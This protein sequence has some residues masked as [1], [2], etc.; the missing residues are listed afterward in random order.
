[1]P[2]GT[3]KGL[4]GAI[5]QLDNDHKRYRGKGMRDAVSFINDYLSKKLVG[6]EMKNQKDID[7]FL[8]DMRDSTSTVGSNVTLSVSK[9]VLNATAASKGLTLL[10]SLR[11]G[12]NIIMPTPLLNIM[13][14]GGHANSQLDFQDFMLIP[15][16]ATS[17]STAIEYGMEISHALVDVLDRRG[18]KSEICKQ[19]C[20]A[21]ILSS[22]EQAIEYILAAIS[23]AGLKCGADIFLGLDLASNAFYKHEKYFLN[24][25]DCAICSDELI[26]YLKKLTEQYP[27]ISIEDG[28][29]EEDLTG[30]KKITS[31]L[32]A[33]IQLVGDDLFATNKNLLLQGIEDNIA[34]AILIKP[35]QVGTITETINTV[36]EAQKHN[37]QNIFSVRASETEDISLSCLCVALGV[38]QFKTGS[39]SSS[40]KLLKI[41]Q[42][43]R[44]E[45]LYGADASYAGIKPFKSISN[46]C[47]DS[48]L[49]V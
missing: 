30:W 28:V 21:P 13:S 17:Y 9:A 15:A 2:S 43:L 37:Y 35:N 48:S 19:N 36:K 40:D 1:M 23:L 10:E 49:S 5:E 20:L 26:D 22:N 12:N 33:N 41:N 42:F 27:I 8:I 34:N 44:I 31:V 46:S 18:I 32:G 29:S 47:S 14:N 3:S 25:K 7:D 11:D 38:T 39:I 16:G 4:K 24:S 45:N 6:F